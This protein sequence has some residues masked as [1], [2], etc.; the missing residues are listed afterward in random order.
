MTKI[1]Q[2]LQDAGWFEPGYLHV[3]Y[4]VKHRRCVQFTYKQLLRKR[5][6]SIENIL[7]NSKLLLPEPQQ[8]EDR[9]CQ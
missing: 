8:S 4:D 6:A 9:A 2:F 5:V 7:W 1:E 3:G